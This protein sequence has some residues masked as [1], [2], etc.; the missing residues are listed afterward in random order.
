[1]LAVHSRQ[2]GRLADLVSS[3]IKAVM[4]RD[5]RSHYDWSTRWTRG[6]SLSPRTQVV[7]VRNTQCVMFT[8]ATRPGWIT[9]L[10]DTEN[11]SHGMILYDSVHDLRSPFLPD[12]RQLR[13]EPTHQRTSS[14]LDIA[15][16]NGF[17]N[18][19]LQDSTFEPFER[20]SSR[21]VICFLFLLTLSS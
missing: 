2:A 6:S 19:S 1:M 16:F 4:R 13:V 3:P 18:F 11:K 15:T 17:G 20:S 7:W 12:L 14:V 10:Y 9:M 8:G 21:L 5:S